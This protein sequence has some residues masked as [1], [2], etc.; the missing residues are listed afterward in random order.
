[1]ISLR[2]AG[3]IGTSVLKVPMP[4]SLLLGSGSGIRVEGS[5]GLG[6]L[7]VLGFI[8][9]IGFIGFRGLGAYRVY[10]GFGIGV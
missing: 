8:G 6:V 5:R 3:R 7:G 1:M 4:K 9:L 2:A 10:K